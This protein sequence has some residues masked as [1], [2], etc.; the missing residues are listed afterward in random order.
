MSTAIKYKRIFNSSSSAGGISPADAARI[1]TLEN[2]EYKVAYFT[3]INSDTGTIITPAGAT[4]LLDQF[5]GGVDAYVST[6]SSSQPTG[7]NPITAGSVVVDVS[8][9]DALGNY[10][11]SDIPS[12][13]PVALIYIL[14]IKAK[15]WI[16]LDT[17]NILEWEQHVY[18][19]LTPIIVNSNTKII[20]V[21]T[22]TIAGTVAAGDDSRFLD[23]VRVFHKNMSLGTAT[24]GTSNTI[25]KSVLIPGGTV[26]SGNSIKVVFI[27]E[28][29]GINGAGT[30]RLYVNDTNDLTTPTL[31]GTQGATLNNYYGASRTLGVR[32]STETLIGPASVNLN[33]DQAGALPNAPAIVNIDWT[34]D[35]Y[36]IVAC[37]CAAGSDSMF[38]NY[39]EVEIH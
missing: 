23:R 13:Y 35:Q 16:N 18:T 17:D 27:S 33:D 20:S 22:G 36:I 5:S 6:I 32:S 2:N 10:T 12:T 37:Q 26:A 1:T 11:L 9:F 3:E 4:I 39:F 15:D 29:V 30:N 8:S 31:I 19:G 14:K 24:S 28:K 38:N 34:V 25:S 7:N 21:T